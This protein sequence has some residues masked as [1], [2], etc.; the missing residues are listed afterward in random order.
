MTEDPGLEPQE[1]DLA[2]RLIGERPLP[3]AEFRGALRRRLAA[4]DPGYGPRPEHLR[5]IV[6]LYLGVGAALGGLGVLQ[7]VG[8]I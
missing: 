3:A 2:G 7:A 4:N 1:Q 6:A 8:V 5:W